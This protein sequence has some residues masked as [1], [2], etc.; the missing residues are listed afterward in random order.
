[1]RA[2][3]MA[4]E[5]VTMIGELSSAIVCDVE[6]RRTLIPRALVLPGSELRKP[7]D[8]GRLVVPREVAFDLGLVALAR[9][10]RRDG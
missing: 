4:V 2:T 3:S 6:G 10:T 5:R 9:R 7:G 8:Q 1:M